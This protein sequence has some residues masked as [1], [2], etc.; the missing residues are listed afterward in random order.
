MMLIFLLLII[1]MYSLFT[2][3]RP[4]PI[5]TISAPP[6]TVVCDMSSDPTWRLSEKE[7]ENLSLKV[8]SFNSNHVYCF[9]KI[10]VGLWGVYEGE[11]QSETSALSSPPKQPHR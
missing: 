6:Q 1:Y 4:K 11:L 5:P 9:R 2:P 10:S 7:M 3:T 8:F